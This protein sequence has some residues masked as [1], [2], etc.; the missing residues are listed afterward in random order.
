LS[1]VKGCISVA[2][3]LPLLN[4]NEDYSFI[5]GP[6]DDSEGSVNRK[7]CDSL[8]KKYIKEFWKPEVS[9]TCVPGEDNGIL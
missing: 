6:V 7:L 2:S 5:D 1:N 8:R 3:T 9:K 4:L